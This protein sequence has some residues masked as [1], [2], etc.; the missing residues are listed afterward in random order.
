MMNFF[1]RLINR[2]TQKQEQNINNK[3]HEDQLL[4]Y[5]QIQQIYGKQSQEW[6]NSAFN[7]TSTLLL[8][9][10][11]TIIKIFQ[12]K[13]GRLKEIK[14]LYYHNINAI[15][16]M[17]NSNQFMFMRNQARCIFYLIALNNSKFQ[18]EQ[19]CN[20]SRRIYTFLMNNKEDFLV[21][22]GDDILI[23]QKQDSSWILVWYFDWFDL[24]IS[25]C[26]QICIS[27]FHNQLICKAQFWKD[28]DGLLCIFQKNN[29]KMNWE[30][31]QKIE[32]DFFHSFCCINEL[33]LL[34]IVDPR[35]NLRIF[36]LK[37]PS[38]QYVN[39][40][41]SMSIKK[42]SF[43][44]KDILLE[45]KQSQYAIGIEENKQFISKFFENPRSYLEQKLTLSA[46]GK[47][48]V[49]HSHFG[50]CDIKQLLQS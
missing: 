27:E 26:S 39:V 35:R 33:S 4:N 23:Y 31:I 21:E 8:L 44:E 37:I 6:R 48:L 17:K 22:Y 9:A 29:D 34:L 15:Y 13:N 7:Q 24:Y 14:T 49:V 50:Q 10:S 46:H 28:G 18:I 41:E 2:F 1:N 40:N 43:R 38:N 25:T 20:K 19:K 5:V 42:L 11:K 32:I 3:N 12:F 36:Q 30:I 47:Y 16:C 45:F